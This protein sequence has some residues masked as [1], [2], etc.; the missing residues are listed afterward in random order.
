MYFEI[1]GEDYKDDLA[2]MIALDHLTDIKNA[3]NPPFLKRDKDGDLVVSDMLTDHSEDLDSMQKVLA[4]LMA[5]VLAMEKEI[6]DN[7]EQEH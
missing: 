3:I 2:A 4:V 5:K 6:Y 7:N 1:M